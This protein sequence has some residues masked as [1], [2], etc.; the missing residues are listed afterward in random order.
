MANLFEIPNY[1]KA[2]SPQGLR[3]LMF[4]AQKRDS[5]QYHFF[6]I[7][8]ANGSWFAWYIKRAKTDIE[9]IQVAKEIMGGE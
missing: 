3:R 7:Q 9:K 5:M 2:A 4:E 8:Y 1:I 6:N